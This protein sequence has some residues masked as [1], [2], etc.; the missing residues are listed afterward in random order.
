M[1]RVNP[2][3]VEAVMDHLT[4][5]VDE[6]WDME[7]ELGLFRISSPAPDAVSTNAATQGTLMVERG[8]RYLAEWRS[9]L[10]LAREALA[11]QQ[12]GYASADSAARA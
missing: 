3:A 1:L 2:T 11:A 9:Q 7:R 12:A 6:L 8:R 10:T 4:A 5:I